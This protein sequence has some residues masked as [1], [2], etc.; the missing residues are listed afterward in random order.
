VGGL[1]AWQPHSSREELILAAAGLCASLILAILV[2]LATPRGKPAPVR[3]SNF[4]TLI[5]VVLLVLREAIDSVSVRSVLGTIAVVFISLALARLVFILG[6]D[7]ILTWQR[8][9][10][11]PRIVR[12]LSQGALLAVAGLASLRTAGVEPGQILTTSALLT[13][14]AGFALQETLG[15]LVA[16]LA[17]Q[18]ER[19]FQ[20]GDW[21]E[22]HGQPGHIGKVLEINWRA[23]RL[24]SLDNVD[25]VVPNGLLAKATITNYTTRRAARRSVYFHTP[26]ATPPKAVHETVL[27]AVRGLPGV[28]TTPEPSI[29]TYAFDDA[30]VQFW[31]RYFIDDM[32]RRDAIDGGVRDRVWY[33]LSRASIPISVSNRKIDVREVSEASEQLTRERALEERLEAVSRIDL[34]SM[35]EPADKRRIADQ[36]RK[37]QYAPGEIVIRQGD[38]GN[39]MFVVLGG[40]LSVRVAIEGTESEAARLSSGSFFGEMSLLT[41]DPRKAT[42]AAMTPC[43][44][45]VLEHASFREI[46]A[47]HPDVAREISKKVIQRQAQLGADRER[48]PSSVAPEAEHQSTVLFGRILRFFGL[49]R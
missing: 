23:T 21:V 19:P 39:T 44:L 35:L 33:S 45:L 18:T 12:D 26:Y 9:G 13:V 32:S 37:A 10:P 27:A 34:F 14:V 41:G 7:V 20:V 22:V 49:A 15:N 8:R 2:R 29:V 48:T 47:P 6:F 28:L 31:L 25:V 11:P 16:G 36:A 3:A 40:E 38:M 1:L 24:L 4:L 42:V 30:G 46:L 43:E 5:Y 17:L